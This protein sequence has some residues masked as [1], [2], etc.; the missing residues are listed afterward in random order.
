MKLI[1]KY[2]IEKYLW[3]LPVKRLSE[4]VSEPGTTQLRI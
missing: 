3:N 1:E 4:N 2:K